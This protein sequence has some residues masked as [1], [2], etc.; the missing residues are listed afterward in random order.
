[1]V[2][3]FPVPSKTPAVGV[4]YQLMFPAAVMAVIVVVP[5]PQ[6]GFTL[7]IV[8]NDISFIIAVTGVRVP[9]GQ[10]GETATA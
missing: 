7:L 2:K 3:L 9:L 10:A 1:M 5:L 4:E 6:I 8:T